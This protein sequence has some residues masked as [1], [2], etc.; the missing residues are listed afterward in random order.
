M[1]RPQ[2]RNKLVNIGNIRVNEAALKKKMKADMLRHLGNK[3]ASPSN[4]TNVRSL[5]Y[6]TRK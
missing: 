5:N 6:Q 1:D 2:I 4:I 3:N